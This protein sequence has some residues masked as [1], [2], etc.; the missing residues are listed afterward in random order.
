MMRKKIRKL[1]LLIPL[2]WA[3]TAY[4][5]AK[6]YHLLVPIPGI[7]QTSGVDLG[8]YLQGMYNFLLGII[9]LVAL[10]YMIMGGMQYIAAGGNTA[11]TGAAKEAITSAI[12]GLLLGILSWVILMTINPDLQF[13][14]QPGAAFKDISFRTSLSGCV[15]SFTTGDGCWCQ[16]T[17]NAKG[18]RPQGAAA[19]LEACDGL[20]KAQGLCG[21]GDNY[22]IA[23]GSPTD[24]NSPG[25]DPDKGCT[26]LDGSS[27][28]LKVATG[29]G[30]SVKEPTCAESC[31]EAKK[32]G[33]KFLVLKLNQHNTPTGGPEG[34]VSSFYPLS[35]NALWNMNLTN[36]GNFG[37]FNI[38][39]QHR[40]DAALGNEEEQKKFDCAIMVTNEVGYG[41]DH[42]W[43]YWVHEGQTISAN[44]TKDNNIY[45]QMIKSDGTANFVGCCGAGGD[46]GLDGAVFSG[47][48]DEPQA[49]MVLQTTYGDKVSDS[50]DDCSFAKWNGNKPTFRPARDVT[51]SNGYWQ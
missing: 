34:S 25:Y 13:I 1:L 15:K 12:T 22:C 28:P 35:G 9:G 30:D 14:K 8:T 7:S 46:C 21:D 24:A 37:D 31:L 26:C 32:C 23:S 47:D 20:C 3:G 44:N 41:T 29:T 42:N 5:A 36:D 39:E 11:K 17:A 16:G 40:V 48:C 2:L 27:T 6:P 51:C 43:V 38:T 50:C 18:T 10:A 4:A 33:F 19:N 49:R 45:T